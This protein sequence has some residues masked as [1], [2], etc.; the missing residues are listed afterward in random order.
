MVSGV[1]ALLLER[2]QHLQGTEVRAL[3]ERTGYTGT[4]ASLRIID[5]CDAV[6]SVVRAEGCREIRTAGEVSRK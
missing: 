6:A 4:D 5:A 2:G 3:L 1:V